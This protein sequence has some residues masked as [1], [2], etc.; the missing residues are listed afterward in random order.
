MNYYV[1]LTASVFFI[2]CGFNVH[3]ELLSGDSGV[4]IQDLLGGIFE[5]GSGIIALGDVQVGILAIISGHI[6]RTHFIKHFQDVS[7][8][9]KSWLNFQLRVCSLNCCG[10]HSDEQ[11]LGADAMSGAHHGDIDI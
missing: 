9:V 10:N 4:D 6:Q 8:Q 2:I 3:I 7:K 5:V 11:A 1:S